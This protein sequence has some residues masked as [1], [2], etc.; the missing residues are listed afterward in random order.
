MGFFTPS[1][2]V[3]YKEFKKALYQL[4]T[5]GFSH[6]E[7]NEI[8]NVFRGDLYESGSS[9]GISKDELN[10]GISWLKDHPDNHHL[11]R[12]RISK[13]EEVLRHYL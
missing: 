6:V 10:K 8:E 12:D 3:S 7:I 13:L 4:R 9:A 1:D 11:S 5:H 2:R